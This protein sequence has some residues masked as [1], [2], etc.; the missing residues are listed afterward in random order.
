MQHNSDNPELTAVVEGTLEAHSMVSAGQRVLAAVSAGLDSMVM[1]EVL[2]RLSA[3]LGF[4]LRV[5]HFDHGLR[6]PEAARA[7]RALVEAR[8]GA[9]GLQL[10]CGHADVAAIAK[11][12]KLNLQDAARRTRYRFFWDCFAQYGCS[13]LATGHHRD[14]QA[15]TVL[16][17]MLSGSGLVGL[18][19]IPVVSEGGR[20]IRP[21][22]N[23]PRAELERFALRHAVAFAQDPSNLSDKYLRNRLR[24][25]LI[26]EIE[27]KFDPDFRDN[28]ILLAGEANRLRG[29]LEESANAVSRET[30]A[31]AAK[32]ARK[33]D[34]LKLEN[35]PALLRRYLL[36]RVVFE[37]TGGEVI[38]SSRALA[39]VERLILQGRS[40]RILDLPGDLRASR[41]FGSL[42]ISPRASMPAGTVE[43]ELTH[44]LP[45]AG[46]KTILLGQAGWELDLEKTAAAR[47]PGAPVPL[48][49]GPDGWYE[50][51][52]D[53][54]EL[55]L[56]L[57]AGAWSA[58]DKMRPFGLGGSKKVKK[59]FQ[60]KRIPA[61]SRS[62]IPV[63]RDACGEVLW[64]CGVARTELAPVV[65]DSKRLLRI[66]A[67]RI[68]LSS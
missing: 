25:R 42:I 29:A 24:H 63:V 59:L 45:E 39:A 22:L 57:T 56:P 23:V 21:L 16:L 30:V 67:R 26:P 10:S 35:V 41:E 27:E 4:D 6:G 61:S 58:G 28:L 1:L 12:R 51:W 18:A 9:L 13:R 62:G 54:E 47:F 2:H 15:E 60:E 3:R 65:M 55:K 34:C 43:E 49:E 66:R 52:F 36:R 64:I 11:K 19:G 37:M 40:G 53:L 38:I 68:E 7:E 48:A 50:Q 14:D 44:E 46:S 32:G 17:R 31:P 8:C 20:L 33:I 5:V